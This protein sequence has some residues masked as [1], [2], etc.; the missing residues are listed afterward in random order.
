[1]NWEK[2]SWRFLAT[3]DEYS[4]LRLYLI[5]SIKILT[6]VLDDDAIVESLNET[7]PLLL[8]NLGK[9]QVVMPPGERAAFFQKVLKITDEIAK[10]R[11]ET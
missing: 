6:G 4:E 7:N 3:G 1:M 2:K 10:T 8:I 11:S 5:H 9:N